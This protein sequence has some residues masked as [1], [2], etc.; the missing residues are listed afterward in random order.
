MLR[1]ASHVLRGALATKFS[2]KWEGAFEVREANDD[3]S[4]AVMTDLS[5][6]WN[7]LCDNGDIAVDNATDIT[8]EILGNKLRHEFTHGGRQ[9]RRFDDYS[10]ASSQGTGL[11]FRSASVQ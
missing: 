2:P 1:V 5:M 6:K 4:D 7:Y 3:V 11:V 9:F 10:V 8:G